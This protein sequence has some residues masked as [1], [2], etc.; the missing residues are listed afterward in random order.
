MSSRTITEIKKMIIDQTECISAVDL[1]VVSTEA[2]EQEFRHQKGVLK[3]DFLKFLV[4]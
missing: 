2:C 3:Q 1:R 4:E